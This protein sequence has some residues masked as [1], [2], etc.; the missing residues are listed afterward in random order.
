MRKEI[1][2]L[3]KEHITTVHSNIF[4]FYSHNE[5]LLRTRTVSMTLS[6][7]TVVVGNDINKKN[8]FASKH[9]RIRNERT[10]EATATDFLPFFSFAQQSSF[11][12][13][14]D[15]GE[16]NDERSR[17]RGERKKIGAKILAKY[18]SLFG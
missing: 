8:S 18:A 7:Q 5:C 13:S 16:T 3:R 6:R 9:A 15:Y 17:E 4:M 12:H 14:N 1:I 10:H 11:S 2:F